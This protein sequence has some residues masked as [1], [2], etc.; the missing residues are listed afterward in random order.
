MATAASKRQRCCD[1]ELRLG[2]CSDDASS[3]PRARESKKQ[4]ATS[5]AP[6]YDGGDRLSQQQLVAVSGGRGGAA[7]DA[8]VQASAIIRMARRAAGAQPSD[9]GAARRRRSLRWFL[10][11]REVRSRNTRAQPKFSPPA[12][13]T[14]KSPPPNLAISVGES[15]W[16]RSSLGL[17]GGS[18]SSYV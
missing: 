9:R 5:G 12:G 1:T 17:E 6:Y 2:G 8:E 3:P 4:A 11:R 7:T 15:S 16:N 18:F 14:P 13:A 10:Q